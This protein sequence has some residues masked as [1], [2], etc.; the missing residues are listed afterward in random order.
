M[1]SEEIKSRI[2]DLMTLSDDATW[3]GHESTRETVKIKAQ[4]LEVM[5]LNEINWSLYYLKEEM[6]NLKAMMKNLAIIIERK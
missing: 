6:K 5:T 4:L 1:Q 3:M 2:E